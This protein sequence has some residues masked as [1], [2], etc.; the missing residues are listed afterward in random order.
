M[1]RFDK[2]Q[3]LLTEL[4]ENREDL[5]KEIRSYD[6]EQ[7]R[8]REQMETIARENDALQRVVAETTQEH[9]LT[10]HATQDRLN[11]V[12][13]ETS[14]Q[15]SRLSEENLR[16]SRECS[17]LLEQRKSDTS[18]INLA[19]EESLT[20]AFSGLPKLGL[21]P[22]LLLVAFSHHHPASRNNM[23]S[24]MHRLEGRWYSRVS[25]M[26]RPL[27]LVVVVV[28]VVGNPCSTPWGRTATISHTPLHPPCDAPFL[29]LLFL[30]CISIS[31]QECELFVL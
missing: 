3:G 17:L 18:C 28:V 19:W 13:R 10:H 6:K 16:L 14:Q 12:L 29:V 21:L 15:M 2:L 24:V 11:K 5:K 23:L 26:R 31:P 7:Q 20:N 27:P 9:F 25:S 30:F 1:D 22:A 4:Q 8:L